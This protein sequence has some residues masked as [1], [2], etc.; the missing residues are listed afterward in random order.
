MKVDK[1]SSKG[2]KIAADKIGTKTL[3]FLN[4]CKKVGMEVT[5]PNKYNTWFCSE[6]NVPITDALVA[7]RS[8]LIEILKAESTNPKFLKTLGQILLKQR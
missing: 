7:A 1:D 6:L 2:T 4:D 5:L 3:N 8:N